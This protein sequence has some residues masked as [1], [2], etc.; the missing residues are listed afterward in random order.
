MDDNDFNAMTLIQVLK[1]IGEYQIEE[2][3]N[4]K[5]AVQMFSDAVNQ[6]CNCK[7]RGHKL[8]LMDIQMPVMDGFE[9]ATK[10]LSL[11]ENLNFETNIVAL[12]SYTSNEVKIKCIDIGMREVYSKPVSSESL[13]EI[14]QNYY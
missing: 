10:I 6:I 8:I 3:Q 4:G 5:I 11:C 13:I 7:N 1:N 14:L 9:A 2:A 12:T